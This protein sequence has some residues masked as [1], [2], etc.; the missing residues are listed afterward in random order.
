MS[1][2]SQWVGWHSAKCL[3]S[4]CFLSAVQHSIGASQAVQGPLL[5]EIHELHEQEKG[6]K[7]DGGG[8]TSHLLFVIAT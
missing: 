4:I 3:P 5:D 1:K 8:C 2:S 7:I 6:M